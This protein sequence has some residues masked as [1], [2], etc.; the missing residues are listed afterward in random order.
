MRR[1][2]VRTKLPGRFGGV[3]ALFVLLAAASAEAQN[4]GNPIHFEND[5]TV[6]VDYHPRTDGNNRDRNYAARSTFRIE[7]AAASTATRGAQAG[8]GVD[9]TLGSLQKDTSEGNKDY[10][11]RIRLPFEFFTDSANEGEETIVV[12]VHI[13]PCYYY[14]VSLF[15]RCESEFKLGEITV[16]LRDGARPQ[17]DVT[18]TTLQITEGESTSYSVKLKSDPGRNTSVRVD[19]P[20]PVAARLDH[21]TR[22]IAE[23]KAPGGTLGRTATLSFTGGA[24]G[25]WNTPQ[26][27]TVSAP[28]DWDT[29][30]D[31]VNLSHSVDGQ[32]TNFNPTVR[33]TVQ[34]YTAGI[35]ISKPALTVHEGGT[36]ATYTVSVVGDPGSGTTI[37]VDVDV[38][39][40]YRS[41]LQVAAGSGAFTSETEVV[42]TGDRFSRGNWRTPQ[43]IRVVAPAT[44]GSH[45]TDEV[46]RVPHSSRRAG[47]GTYPPTGAG[48]DLEVTLK[49][50]GGLARV[51]K[52]K[53]SVTEGGEASYDLTFL[54]APSKP[55]SVLVEV[56]AARRETVKLQTGQGQPGSSV[57]LEYDLLRIGAQTVK[58]LAL[59][60]GDTQDETPFS[61]THTAVGFGWESGREPKVEV[62]V[63]DAGAGVILSPTSVALKEPTAANPT[64]PAATATYKV[65]L[66]SDPGGT[67]TVTPTSSVPAAVTVAPATLTFAS[68]DWDE[69]Q[70]VTLTAVKDDNEV[71][72]AVTI[73][74]A[75]SGYGAVTDGGSVK[76]NLTDS[77]KPVKPVKPDVTATAPIT[78]RLNSSQDTDQTETFRETPGRGGIGLLANPASVWISLNSAKRTP[79]PAIPFRLCYTLGTLSPGDVEAPASSGGTPANCADHVT[80]EISGTLSFLT[81]IVEV[82]KVTADD[83][84][85]PRETATVTLMADPDNPL[86]DMVSIVSSSATVDLT[87]IDGNDDKT[88]I[89]LDVA[90]SEPTSIKEGG[91]LAFS[92]AL[93]RALVAGEEVRVPLTVGGTGVTAGDYTLALTSGTGASLSAAAPWTLTFKGAGA[94]TAQLELRAL[95]DRHNDGATETLSVTVGSATSNLH[96]EDPK[97]FDATGTQITTGKGSI[98]VDIIDLPVIAIA[99]GDDVTEGTAASFTVSTASTLTEALTVKLGIAQSGAFVADGDLGTDK[100]IEIPTTGSAIYTVATLLDKIDE[101][102]GSVTATLLA[103]PNYDF[104]PDE[105]AAS[106]KVADDD[107]TTVSLS[108]PARVNEGSAARVT[109]T[110][111]RVLDADVAIPIA[112]SVETGDTAEADDFSAP[113]SIAIDAGELSGSADVDT[114]RDADKDNERFTVALGKTLPD[115]IVAGAPASLKIAITDDGADPVVSLA[116]SA[117]K[118]EDGGSITITANLSHAAAADVTVP[119]EVAGSGT[120][121]AEASEWDAPAGIAIEKGARSGSAAIKLVRDQDKDDET[122]TVSLGASLPAGIDAGSPSSV[123]ITIEDDGLGHEITLSASAVNEGQTGTV[124]ATA[125]GVFDK[126]VTIPLTFTPAGSKKAEATDFKVPSPAS[127]TIAAA[128]AS[129]AVSLVTYEDRDTDDDVV[130]VA[131]GAPLPAGVLG[132][133]AGTSVDVTIKDT[134]AASHGTLTLSTSPAADEFN[135]INLDEGASLTLTASIDKAYHSDITLGLSQSR[136]GSHTAEAG[137]YTP[138]TGITIPAGRTSANG[139]IAASQD[140]DRDDETFTVRVDARTLPDVV[141]YDVVDPNF[142]VTIVDDDDRRSPTVSASLGRGGTGTEVSPKGITLSL[143]GADT[144]KS[145]IIKY[146]LEQDGNFLAAN[147]EGEQTVTIRGSSPS[148]TLPNPVVNDSVDEPNGAVTLTLLDGDGYRVDSA[149][150]TVS[151]DVGDDDPTRVSLTAPAGNISEGASKTFTVGLGRALLTG[152]ELTVRVDFDGIAGLNSD[153]S[154]VP[155]NPAPSGV[156]FGEIES[157]DRLPVTFTG[158][159]GAAS[160]A[161]FRLAT[162]NDREREGATDFSDSQAPTQG[163]TCAAGYAYD[164]FAQKCYRF[165]AWEEVEAELIRLGSASGTGLGGGA[166]ADPARNEVSFRINDDDN[167]TAAHITVAPASLVVPEGGSAAYYVTLNAGNENAVT[168]TPTVSPTSARVTI[169]PA[170]ATIEQY[171]A[172]YQNPKFTVTAAANSTPGDSVNLTINHAVTG[173][174]SVTAP[175]VAVRVTDQSKKIVATPASLSVGANSTGTFNLTLASRPETTSVRVVVESDATAVA[176]VPATAFNF[177]RN[178]WNQAQPVTVTGVKK[179]RASITAKISDTGTGAADR[180]FQ[181]VVAPV[182]VTADTRPTVSLGV[183]SNSVAEGASAT[184]TATLSAAL[185][186]AAAVTIPLTYTNGTAENA[187]YTRAASITID[188]GKTSGTASLAAANNNVYEGDETLTVALGTLP[189]GVR[190]GAASSQTVTIT[191]DSDLPTV[192]VVPSSAAQTVGENKGTASVSVTWSGVSEVAASVK[193]ASADG[194]AEAGKDYAGAAGTLNRAVSSRASD[195][196]SISL[197]VTDDTVDDPGAAETFTVTLSDP[198][199]ARLGTNASASVAITDNDPTDV[200]LIAGKRA[201]AEAAGKKTV[202]VEVTRPLVSGESLPVPLTFAGA[203]TFGADY[204]I[205]EPAARPR[206]VTYSNLAST[207]LTSSPPT[208]TFAGGAGNA[209]IATVVLTAK[210]DTDVE[211]AG[212]TVTVG[213]GTLGAGSGSGLGGGARARPT[214]MSQTFTITDDDGK[215]TISIASARAAEGDAGE[216]PRLTFIVSLSAASTEA[217]SVDYAD[218]GTG[219]ATAG[220][221]YVAVAAGTLEFKAGETRKTIDVTLTGDGDDEGDETIVLRLSSPKNAIFAGSAAT[222]D[223]TG[224]IADDDTVHTLTVAGEEVDEGGAGDTPTLTFTVT[225]NKAH[226]Q[227]VTVD[228][229]DSAEGTATSGT[230]YVAITAGTLTFKAGET[231]KTVEVTLTGDTDEEEDETIVLRLSKPTNAGFPAVAATLDGTGTIANDDVEYKISIAP[232]AA[233][234]VEGAAAQFVLTSDPAPPADL[235]VKLAATQ[236]GSRV[237]AANLNVTSAVIPATKTSSANIGIATQG[238]TSDDPDGSVTLTI[239]DDAA[240]AI[241]AGSASVAVT[242][243]DATTV[244]LTSSAAAPSIVEGDATSKA[245]LTLTLGRDLVAGEVVD[246]PLVITSATGVAVAA[247]NAADRDYILSATGTGVTLTGANTAAPKVRITGAAA[248]EQSATID[249]TATARDDGDETGDSFTVKLGDLTAAG[250]ATG[251]SGGLEPT[252][253]N[254][255]NTTDNQWDVAIIDNDVKPLLGITRAAAHTTEGSPA[256]F[257][258]TLAPA[259]A[260]P[261]AVKITVGETSGFDHVDA[262]EEGARTL[263]VPAG[264][265]EFAFEVPTVDNKVDE[266]QDGG[267]TVTLNADAAYRLDTVTSQTIAVYDDDRTRATFERTDDNPERGIPEDGGKAVVKFALSRALKAGETLTWPL[268]FNG[269]KLTEDFTYRLVPGQT[270]VTLLTAH[271]YDASDPALQLSGAGV[272]EGSIEVTAIDDG[273]TVEHRYLT[274][275][276]GHAIVTE[277]PSLRGGLIHTVGGVGFHFLDAKVKP[278]IEFQRRTSPENEQTHTGEIDL[279]RINADPAPIAD[280]DVSITLEQRGDYFS[281]FSLAGTSVSTPGTYTLTIPAHHG[282]RLWVRGTMVDDTVDE[283]IGELKLKVN[284]GSDYTVKPVAVGGDVIQLYDDDGGPTVSISAGGPV[285][286]AGRAVFTVTRTSTGIEPVRRPNVRLEISMEGDVASSSQLGKYTLDFGPVSSVRTKTHTVR[287]INDDEDEADGKI[288]AKLLPCTVNGDGVSTCAVDLPPGNRAEVIVTDDDEAESFQLS[289]DTATVAENVASAPTVTVTAAAV[290]GVAFGEAHDITVSIGATGDTATSPAD[291]AAVQDFTITVPA[292]QVSATGS[293][294]LT[295]VN[296]A[297][298]ETDETLSVTGVSGNL[299]ILPATITLTDDEAKPTVSLILTPARIDESGNSNESTVTAALSGASS[300]DVELTVSAAA[301]APAQDAAFTLSENKTLTITAGA[302]ASTGAVTVTSVDNQVDAADAE[303][304]VSAT[305]TGGHDVAAPADA[306]LTITDDDDPPVL[307][308]SSPTVTEGDSGDQTAATLTF[309]VSL[310]AASGKTVT[311]AYADTKTGTAASATDYT[312]I[313]AGTLSFAAGETEKTVA[314]TITGDDLD[315]TNETVILRLSSPTNATLAGGVTT[316]DGTG[317]I[318][319]DDTATLSI[320]DATAAEGASATFTIRLS[321]ARSTAT[322][323][324]ATTSTEA[325]DT[326]TAPADYTHKTQALTIAA[327]STS[328]TFTVA[329]IDD[330]LNELAETFT[331]TLSDASVTIDDPTATGTITGSGAT[332]ISIANATAVEGGTLS[333]A[334]TRSGDTSGVSSLTWTT[335]DDTAPGAKKATAPADYTA[336]STAQTVRFLATETTKTITVTSAAD[337]LIDGDETFRVNLASPAGAVLASAFATGT[338]T[339]GTTGYKI[340]DANADEGGMITFTITREGLTTAAGSVKW[341]TTDDTT[342]GADK[343]TATDDYTPVTTARTVSFLAGETSKDITVTTREDTTDEPDETFRVVLSAPSTGILTDAIGIGTINDDD[344]PTLSIANAEAGEGED[345]TFTV[346]LTS[347]HDADVKVT[348]TTSSETSDTATATDDYTTKT[349]ELTLAAG[350]TSATFTV[351]TAEDAIDEANE[352][353]TVTLTGATPAAV[354]IAD[355]TATGTITDDDE[356]GITISETTVT[357]RESDDGDTTNTREDRATYT[358]VLDSEP[359]GGT[360]TIN[361]ASED[362]AIATV[363]PASIDFTAGNW[364]TAVTVTVTGVNDDTDNTADKRTT[365]ITHTVDAEDTDYED[366]EAGD[367]EVEVTDDDGTPTATLTLAPARIDES[368]ASNVTT[369]TANLSH[370]SGAAV[371]VTVA[372]AAVAPAKNGDFTLSVNKTLTIAKGATTSTGEVTIT[373]VDNAVD[374]AD[375]SVT[376][377]ATAAGGGVANPANATLTITDNDTRGV[378]VTPTALPALA[379]VDD[380]GTDD[381]T[382]NEG[383]YEVVLTSR[384]T[385]TVTVNVASFDTKI[386]TVSASSLTFAPADW[387]EAQEVTVTAVADNYDNTGGKRSTTI[388]H[389]VSATGTDYASETASSVTVEVTDDDAAPAIALSASPA[390]VAESASATSVTVTATLSGTTRL[391][392]EQKVRVTVGDAD[393]AAASGID[394]GAVAAFDVTI[395]RDAASGSADF[396]LNPT[397]DTIDEG[398]GEAITVSGIL[399][400]V[401]V[402]NTSVTIT[403]DDD[404]PVLSISS[405]TVTEGDSGDQTAATLTFTVSLNAASGKTVTVAYADTETGTAA[406]G[407]DYTAITAGTLSFAAGETEKTVTVTVTGDDLDESHETV[408]LRLSSPTNATLT[409]GVTRLDGT[410]TITDDDTAALSIDDVTVAE[411]ATAT[412]TITLS[413]ESAADVTVTATTAPGTATAPADYTHKTQALTIDAGDTSAEFTVSVSADDIGELAETFTVGLSRASTTISDG[414]GTGTIIGSGDTLISIANAMAVEGG[415]L[416]FAV[417]RSGDTSGV[418]SLTWTTGDDTAPGAKKATA[419][420]DYTAV[421]TAQTVRFLAT[422]TTKTITVTSAADSLIDG[423]ETF[424]VNLA[425]PAGAVL[426]SAFATGTITEG[427]TGYKIADADADEGE[428]ITFT[429]TREGLTS[430]ASSV[431]WNTTDDTTGGADKATATDDYTPVTTARTVSFLA[432]ETSKDI[433]VTTRED[434]TD[435][436]D[437]TFR[438]VLSAPSTGI[439]TDAIGIGTINDDD[440]P[441]LSIANAEAGEGEDMTFTVSLT[442]AHDADVKVTA[443]TSS[444][445]SD[446]ATATADYTTKTQELTLAAGATSATFT[447]S[448]AEDAIDEANETFTVTLTGASPAAVTIADATATGTITDDDDA[449]TVSV[450]NATAVDEGDVPATTTGMTFPV[451]LSAASGKTVTVAYTLSG[452]ADEPADYTEPN[453]LSV[454]IAAGQASADIV[455]PVRGD[456]TD[457]PDETIVVTLGTLTNATL[458][459]AEGAGTGTGTI[460]DDD[461]PPVLSISAASVT[462]GDSGDQTAAT[463]TFTVSLDAA[464][465][466]TVTVAYADAETGTAASGTDYAEI[467]AGTLSF[468]AGQTEKT[469]DVTVTGDDLDEDNETVILRLSAPTNATLTGGVTTLDGTGTITD[470]D[471]ATLSIDD[472]TAA[473]GGTATFT[474]RLSTARSTATTVTATTSTEATDTATAP[475]DYTHKTQALSIAAGSTTA[476]FTVALIDDSLNE[477]AETFTVTLSDASVTISDPT[478]TGTIIGSGSTLISIANA[479]A[480]EGSALSFAVTRSGDVSGAS[481]F[482]W[483]TGDD[484]TNGANKATADTDYTEVDTAQTVSFSASETTKTI[485]VT[486]TADDL[487]DG[488][489]T[490]R[491]KLANPVG[492]VLASNFAT[493]TITEG[494]TGYAIADASATEGSAITFTITRTGLTTGASSVKWVTADDTT[495]G[496]N[497]AT[498][499][500]DYTAVTTAATVS[501][502]ADETAK[503][504]TVDT[505]GDTTDEPDETFRVNLSAPSAGG[506]LI[507]GTATGTINDNDDAPTVSVG[508]ATAVDEGDVPATTTDMTFTVTLSAVSGKTVTVAYT[509]SGTATAPGDYTVPNPREV[510][511]A[512]GSL[513]ADIDIP[514]KGDTTD[515]TNET[516]IVTLGTLTNATLSSAEG[517]GTGTGTINDDDDPPVLSIS[518][519]SVTEGDSTDETA[520]TLTFTVSLAAASGKTVTV[521]Y[522][523][524]ETGTAT[525]ETD[526][527]EITGA[528]LTFAPGQT[529]KTVDVTVTG[530][531]LDESNE[532]VVLRLSSPTNATFTGGVTTLD[533]TGTITDDDTATLSIDDVTVAEGATATFTISLSTESATDVTV[534]ATTAPGTATAPA[535]YTH[536]TQAL[537]IDAGDTSAEFT[538]SVAADTIGE[539]DET[540][541]VVLSRAS[542]TISDDTGTGT[543]T[544]SDT[545]ITIANATAVEG[546]DLSF[547]LTRSGDL[548]AA[549]SVT[550]TTGDDTANGASKATAGTDYTAVTQA[551]TVSFSANDTRKTITVTSLADSLIDGAETFRVN[552]ASATGA[553]LASAFATGTITE[554]TTGYAIADASATEGTAITF[555]ITRTGLTTGASSVKWVTAADAAG[556]HPAATS[557]YTAVT[558]AATV[559]F[560]AGETSKDITVATTGDTTDEHDETFLVNL[561]APSAGGTLIRGAATGTINDN[562]DAPIVSVGDAT[563]VDEGDVPATTTDMTFPV[564]LSA[565]SG[566]TVTVAYTLGGTADEPADYTEPDPL[567]VEIAAGAMSA[568]ITIPV[569]GDTTDEPNET[570]VVTL[571]TLTNATLSSA[572]GAGTG[573]GTIEDDDATPTVSLTLT[574]ATIDESGDDNESTVTASLSGASS[575]TVTLTVAASGA[576]GIRTLSDNTTLTIAAGDTDSTGAVTVTAVDNEIDAAADATVTISATASGGGVANPTDATLTITDDDTRDVIIKGSPVTVR[577]SDDTD[578]TS[579]REDQGAYTIELATEPTGGTVTVNIAS[580]DLT[581]ATV[582]PASYTFT[583]AN[584]NN[585]RT[586]TVTGVNDDTDNAADKRTTAITHTVD[587]EDTDYE[588]EEAGEVEVEVTDDDATPTA[589]LTLTPARIDESGASNETTV[590]ASLSN[591]SGSAVTFTVA[592]AAVSPA[593]NSAFTLSTNKTLTIAKGATASTGEVTITA[594]DNAVDA[595][596]ASVTVSATA[597]GGGVANPANATLTITDDDTRGVTVTPTALPALAEVDDAATDDAKENE[598]VYEVVLTSRPTGT[599]TVNVASSG[600]KIA[601][602]SASTLTFAPADWNQAQEVTVTAV[603]DNY[604]NTGGKRSTTITHTVSATGT[605]YASETASSVTVEVTDDDAAPAIALSAAPASVA[606]SASATSVTVTATMTGTTRFAAEQKVPRHRRRRGRRRRLRHRLRRGGGL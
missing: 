483:T 150:S 541:T 438:V 528:T 76:V 254:D 548:S 573:T 201:I 584:W 188:S 506:T 468:A 594:V 377:S 417:T 325:A 252:D 586:V 511:I 269:P 138:L 47:L 215:P 94:Q 146:K 445:T 230:D 63:K 20:P 299:G 115:G 209:R 432:G 603:P 318:T 452:T 105:A 95:K 364:N 214:E 88:G 317:T 480:V 330:S 384:P 283:P 471:E 370:P 44:F 396:S 412:F 522:A 170:S 398:A 590:T 311:V 430:A 508:N 48:P 174:G 282:G 10:I 467:T 569:K 292:N 572:E 190:K 423:D 454:E 278:V 363:S 600:T 122:F 402:T 359:T 457:E 46:I 200:R 475:A 78:V 519:A 308:I 585:P 538:V 562:D 578:T 478:A 38:P 303:V 74:H 414:T 149:N 420:A 523:D 491:V 83:L 456:T 504:I 211:G 35:L 31:T 576:A 97:D 439:L 98:S 270:G 207:N 71:S 213:L 492:A 9:F 81:E 379:E 321:T 123:E 373:A 408:I 259:P 62:T 167:A 246:V 290:G 354:T 385:G 159:G 418:S 589:T 69:P 231:E 260:L 422:E 532:T 509:L 143:T 276:V 165:D 153:Y 16:R 428:T 387:N 518:A 131:L 559:N 441:T 236:T 92:A 177:N 322:T 533:G 334:V 391:P 266:E 558:T 169:T 547:T 521:A 267:V 415:T 289:V 360:V 141:T 395:A 324:T 446:T 59:P 111:T 22:T 40:D 293:F 107:A 176:T 291:Y 427:T 61:L 390:S 101:E 79:Y 339:E 184:L 386:A 93:G 540:F 130:R 8:A 349:Q 15:P 237:T 66:K 495:E 121:P 57:T 58:V 29:N 371:T 125:N 498:A 331:V 116:A 144:S 340:A 315:E 166:E 251:L 300:E 67:A 229:A 312:A 466:K 581:A 493:G 459:S 419:P 43:Q 222:L 429:I 244:G 516:I 89:G 442:S 21:P 34:D 474:I 388:T 248:T 463:L 486:S 479:S 271:P 320:D 235:T 444:E 591:P 490:F 234:V 564:T 210:Q 218:R 216:S 337:S 228:Y 265:T 476:T 140:A 460:E 180:T 346:S 302:T 175:S 404:P 436:P 249:F 110:L 416:S 232:V 239:Q 580:A 392:A 279:F 183:N 470:D 329:L 275:S 407:T 426:A 535:D 593:A 520:A 424:R 134:K 77:D 309:T 365:T 25:N 313:T 262:D 197:T 147:R 109:A 127:V 160:S 256:Q 11:E 485:T 75:V 472:A 221:D 50:T 196:A 154:L 137:D 113:A 227:E 185:S 23:V 191:D 561:S 602:V 530:D 355:A 552:L 487:V 332:L 84:D 158:G 323:V 100:T 604:D 204:T 342:G 336:V 563:A 587:A 82:F 531:D 510:E 52:G 515:E 2:G 272:K 537:T 453:P 274:I 451:T 546:S 198:V 199:G 250:V 187:D 142:Y 554:G 524:A 421:S 238:D 556:S 168:I 397:Q 104:V 316:L 90:A 182:T 241:K 28:V 381:A 380:A 287:L 411:G 1:I 80:T 368:G 301:V 401:T 253:D 179:G 553:A 164:E 352:T 335:G 172:S 288:I 5:G 139:A 310:D 343:A 502:L 499:G 120:S 582:S 128:A 3:L 383:V 18:P 557:D 406:S 375:A 458:S 497:R 477:L 327:G 605:D 405:P 151:F 489:E 223:G 567:S 534:T 242:D 298:H 156:S 155:Q 225:L 60:D 570:I 374:A 513:S 286:E 551:R 597:A 464:S 54:V 347:A 481:S 12:V 350:A 544:G 233:S 596:D 488:D 162:V 99:A 304:T 39:A 326:A 494:T 306:T 565:V 73:G 264:R 409:G 399:A 500:T 443:T 344:A 285:T 178:N 542:T 152:E 19:A 27:V 55:V 85:E 568:D 314:V 501:F 319:D 103:D 361:L 484:T 53:L 526:Y 124:T 32:A 575:E 194:T 382:E 257:K 193:Y 447:V 543:I 86:P 529:E 4:L 206:G 448:T 258:L 450:G 305:A 49:A 195:A 461:D 338:I 333:F 106:V 372:A 503:D 133:G 136:D 440:A 72:E 68:A 449:P 376:V 545:L 41:L 579:T 357:V 539:L 171:G 208:I 389:T 145:Y 469:V 173:Y 277:A 437:E 42:F 341:N 102:D 577:E 163:T 192:S 6:L 413:T 507:Q 473:E 26:T 394:Y 255:P 550:W 555:T 219:S 202:T 135:E 536:K 601:T 119:I 96:T 465:G 261:L 431:K 525:S 91:K 186:P 212:E 280:L 566:K 410:G 455:I 203:A 117:T 517:A 378:A 353:F 37:F 356:R 345:M 496:A 7:L 462:E 505:T 36:E 583:A 114:V 263:N 514:V 33:L 393:D 14:G 243:D 220:T 51:S 245:S 592:A 362:E 281:A 226:D 595:A 284:A 64:L 247:A 70:T 87:I 205:A 217:I 348:A 17:L 598:G 435:E 358:V 129:G 403:D 224:T 240:Y 161:T 599:V 482:T 328:A 606:E 296:D 157:G 433:T 369:V 189:S 574:P 434:T 30:N 108:A 126:S 268:H 351:S 527:A 400:G 297:V 132:S 13:T 512:A 273:A 307:S 45:I 294:R 588:D 181:Q 112:A 295:P 560:L 65:S 118:A 367:V 366:E 549:S 24:G 425:S 56:P 571:G 148:L